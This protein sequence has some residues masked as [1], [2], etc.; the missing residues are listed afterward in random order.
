M[1]GAGYIQCLIDAGGCG[2]RTVSKAFDDEARVAW[3]RR[4]GGANAQPL[5]P[6]PSDAEREAGYLYSKRFLQA[7]LLSQEITA[8]SIESIQRI[9]SVAE[10]IA[11]ADRSPPADAQEVP[12]E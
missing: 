10:R 5:F 4:S 1:R 9:L 11:H 3:N 6:P 7:I 12:G 8:G 2:A